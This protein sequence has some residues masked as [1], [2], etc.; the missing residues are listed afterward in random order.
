MVSIGQQ[1]HL[2][3]IG[4]DIRG[5]IKLS[6][7]ETLPQP[8]SGTNNVVEIEGSFS[9]IKQATDS[10]ASVGSIPTEQEKQ[11]SA[12]SKHE[13]SGVASSSYSSPS[14]LIRSAA[15]CDEEEKSTGLK[16]NSKGGFEA[17]MNA[18]SLKIGVEVTSKVHQIR[19]RGL[20][21]DLGG[22]IRGMYRFEVHVHPL[23]FFS[24][25]LFL[26]SCSLLFLMSDDQLFIHL[27]FGIEVFA[28]KGNS[29]GCLGWLK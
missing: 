20:V 14:I 24:A 10:W 16:R 27:E 2:K 19:A 9:Q 11:H 18:K 25:F 12:V 13:S 15:E 8:R 23:V 21:L 4:Q 3:C 5:N 29:F 1:L 22:G 17:P 28:Y 26:N 6:L 7:K